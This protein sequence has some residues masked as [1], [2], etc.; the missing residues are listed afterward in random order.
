MLCK[1]SKKRQNEGPHGQELIYCD[2]I[3][4]VKFKIHNIKKVK[5]N[6]N[7]EMFYPFYVYQRISV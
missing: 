4:R 1:N 2:K 5:V 6:I 7:V 3:K